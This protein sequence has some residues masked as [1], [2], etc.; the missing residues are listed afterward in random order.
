MTSLWTASMPHLLLD[1]PTPGFEGTGR[2]TST[3]L[4]VRQSRPSRMYDS[5]LMPHGLRQYCFLLIA[6]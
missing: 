4:E 6:T 5:P 1:L 2:L 3:S